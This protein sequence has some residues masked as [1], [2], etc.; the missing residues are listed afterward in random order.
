M[1]AKPLHE[2]LRLAD[3][4]FKRRARLL[5]Q[6]ELKHLDFMKLMPANHAALLRP[7]TS[8]FLAIARRKREIFFRQLFFFQNFIPMQV[9]QRGF[10]RR[11]QEF[12][13]FS[14]RLI[15]FDVK[16]VF[17][18]FR[19]LAGRVAALIE[20]KMRRQNKFVAVFQMLFDEIIEQ[21]P[22]QFRAIA[23]VEPEAAP[24]QLHAALIIHQA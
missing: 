7:V 15:G 8:G 13:K 14:A 9:N 19:K 17:L 21:A 3:Q 4:F 5:R 1:Q 11:Q 10:R 23:L 22:F 2:P 18:K 20:Q 12:R 6:G 16:H 24:A